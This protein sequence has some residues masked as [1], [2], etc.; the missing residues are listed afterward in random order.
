MKNAKKIV[1]GGVAALALVTAS[2]MGTM[3]YFTNKTE[4]VNNTFTVGNVSIKLDE[5]P[6][7]INGKETTG[8]RRTSNT[9]KLYPGS[10]YDKDPTITVTGSEDSYLFV[11]VA[12][13]I[14]GVEK[15]ASYVN[16]EGN[17]ATGKIADQM[18]A[19]GWHRLEVETDGNYDV[20][21]YGTDSEMTPVEANEKK[22]VFKNFAISN[23]VT[24]KTLSDLVKT[25]DSSAKTLIT[26]KGY[27]I[28]SKNIA[29]SGADNI[30]SA[31]ELVRD[32]EEGQSQQ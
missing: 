14:S 18:A 19:Y 28:Q 2:V 24:G 23:D 22:P 8:D 10:E 21:Y 15:A 31:W 16:A 29:N 3:A 12:N 32:A 17:K 6:V 4:Q 30:K 1:M 25:E 20:Y 5:A 9:Y 13:G 11:K 7:D 27:A 26:V